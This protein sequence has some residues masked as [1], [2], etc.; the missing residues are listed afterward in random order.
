MLTGSLFNFVN[1]QKT[2]DLFIMDI[3]GKLENQR[4]KVLLADDHTFYSLDLKEALSAKGFDVRNVNDGIVGVEA[5][6]DDPEYSAVISN[7]AVGGMDA[8]SFLISSKILCPHTTTI[9]IDE[10]DNI[11]AGTS[12]EVD[13]VL[14]KP[15]Q[16][17]QWVKTI[18]STLSEHSNFL[19][20]SI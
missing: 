4:P 2:Q 6:L 3:I 10:S 7:L 12:K 13:L 19:N 8:I 15:F 11:R 1:N 9:L 5:L 16:K 14:K 17:D 20:L 18:E